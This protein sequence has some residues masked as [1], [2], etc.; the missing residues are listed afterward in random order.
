MSR[1]PPDSGRRQGSGGS[2]G[3]STRTSI[4]PA[5]GGKRASRSDEQLAPSLILTC[6]I[7]LMRVVVSTPPRAGSRREGSSSAVI[8]RSHTSRYASP[9]PPGIVLSAGGDG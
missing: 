6:Q 3:V 9:L 7:V 4:C 2:G 8:S 5:D 1:R